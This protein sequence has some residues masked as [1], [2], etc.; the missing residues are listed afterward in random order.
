MAGI[1]WQ[2]I[3]V[4]R[5]VGRQEHV[6]RAARQLGLSQP[7][8]SRAVARLE[9]RLGVEL[10]QR[11]GRAVKLTPHG[12]E[13]LKA[14]DNASR[15][16]ELAEATLTGRTARPVSVGFVHT[17]GVRLVPTL[18]QRFNAVSPDVKFVFQSGNAPTFR[19]AVGAR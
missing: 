15:Q 5:V 7:A 6:S 19:R 9:A 13:F 10:F 11:L 3:D 16:V 2:L 1:D 8:V 18:V 12:A 14:V 4:F 17:L